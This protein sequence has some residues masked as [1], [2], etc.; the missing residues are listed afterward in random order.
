MAELTLRSGTDYNLAHINIGRLLDR[1]RNSAGD[2]LRRH[3]E[4]V[5]G[6][7]ELGFHLRICHSFR[8][9][10]VD[11]ARRNDRHAQLVAGLLPQTFGDGTPGE[12]RA[13]IDRLVRF[14]DKSCRRSSVNEMSE[15]LL[16]EDRQRCGDAVQNPF[17]VDVD[18]VLPLC[19]AQVVEWRDRPNAGIVDQDVKLTVPL[20]GQVDEVGDVVAASYV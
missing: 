5:P 17:D 13:G 4:L 15:T 7:F 18:H 2:R 1:E 19:D 10:R 20:T 9:V 14:S 3:G 11:E 16:A 8:E 12:L 6:L